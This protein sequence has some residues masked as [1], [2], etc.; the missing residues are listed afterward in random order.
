MFGW[1]GKIFASEKSLERGLGILER[2]GDALFH[3]DEEKAQERDA[4]IRHKDN[5]MAN[6]IE[7]SKGSNMSRRF[8]AFLVGGIW[9]LYGTTFRFGNNGITGSNGARLETFVG[10]CD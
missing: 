9:A 6:W 4:M 8:L 2:T 10:T 5:F 1:V 7:A 3:T